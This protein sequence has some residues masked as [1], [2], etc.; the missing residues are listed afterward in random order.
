MNRNKVDEILKR[1]ENTAGTQ[2][3][4]VD[5][6]RYCADE[7]DRLNKLLA[8]KDEYIELLSTELS[9]VSTFLYVHGQKASDETIAKGK[10]LREQIKQ[11]EEQNG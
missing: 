5:A 6:L 2:L 7:I 1:Y 10:E 3:E 8:L 4:E 9:R 11:M